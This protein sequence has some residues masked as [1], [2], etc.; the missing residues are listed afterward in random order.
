MDQSR[1][2][3]ETH[4]W[5]NKM[6]AEASN[7]STNDI[8]V[9]AYRNLDNKS[10]ALTHVAPV[11]VYF[12]EDPSEL[13]FSKLYAYNLTSVRNLDAVKINLLMLGVLIY[14]TTIDST[15]STVFWGSQI[16]YATWQAFSEWKK[17]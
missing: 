4:R 16:A 9:S 6:K 8:F 17:R 12:W 5:F 10:S 7:Y 15:V 3:F 2:S 11:A 13:A 14:L 1:Q